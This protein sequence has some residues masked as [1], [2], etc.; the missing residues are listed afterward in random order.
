MTLEGVVA[1]FDGARGDGT[2]VS[3]N[4]VFYFHCVSIRDGSRSIEVGVRAR[5]TRAVGRL[6]RDEVVDVQEVR[7][8]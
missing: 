1:S 5:A 2:F 8:R 4:E 7:G 6:G 3:D